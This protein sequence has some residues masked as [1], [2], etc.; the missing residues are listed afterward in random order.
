M[1]LRRRNLFCSY[2]TKQR[3]THI[4]QLIYVRKKPL[5]SHLSNSSSQKRLTTKT[6]WAESS[7]SFKSILF[8]MCSLNTNSAVTFL[9]WYQNHW[10]NAGGESSVAFLERDADGRR[11]SNWNLGKEQ[12]QTKF[13]DLRRG[14]TKRFLKIG[15]VSKDFLKKNQQ[16]HQF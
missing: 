11:E 1:F 16:N 13:D 5:Q 15:K 10:H 7:S 4:L 3:F 2:E 6:L 14:I 8:K 12:E 9:L